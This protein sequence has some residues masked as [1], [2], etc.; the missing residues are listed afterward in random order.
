MAAR[1]IT[2]YEV[3]VRNVNTG[4]DQTQL[5]TASASPANI[6]TGLTNGTA[7]KFRVRAVN[8]VGVGC[9]VGL[10]QHGDTYRGDDAASDGRAA[11]RAHYRHRRNGV[12]GGTVSA[13]AR[14]SP[15]ANNGGSAITGYLVTAVRVNASGQ[16][17]STGQTA[18]MTAGANATPRR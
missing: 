13:T 18:T 7:Y 17:H 11:G 10:L 15:P 2:G 12:A 14:W 16:P 9:G 1:A 5:R 4:T 8:A 6:T 3:Q